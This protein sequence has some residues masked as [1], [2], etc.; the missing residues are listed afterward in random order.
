MGP[1]VLIVIRNP[2]LSVIVLGLLEKL[3][4]LPISAHVIA[5]R[6]HVDVVGRHPTAHMEG[7]DSTA[8]EGVLL[9]KVGHVLAAIL[10]ALDITREVR[11]RPVIVEDFLVECHGCHAVAGTTLQAR[12]M[13]VS[14]GKR[15][16]EHHEYHFGSHG[17]KPQG[18][19]KQ[20]GWAMFTAV[21]LKVSESKRDLTTLK[22]VLAV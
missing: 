10:D 5:G 17:R 20:G 9:G 22:M 2:G 19:H 3:G 11:T 1:I 21:S 8:I 13:M 12:G 15:S 14:K 7:K 6:A 16:L 18:I 4:I